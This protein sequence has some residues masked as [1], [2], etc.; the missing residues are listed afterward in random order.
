MEAKYMDKETLLKYL[1]ENREELEDKYFKNWD[2]CTY[3]ISLYLAI[4]TKTGKIEGT[5][6]DNW[7]F[8]DCITIKK[9]GTYKTDMAKT[10][11]DVLDKTKENQFLKLYVK[12]DKLYKMAVRAINKHFK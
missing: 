4:N 6:K 5:D 11:L 10:K 8:K 2:V 1:E 7:N 9:I 12:N 3:G